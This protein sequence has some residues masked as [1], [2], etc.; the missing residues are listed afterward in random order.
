[1]SPKIL[2]SDDD[3][4][5]VK[6]LRT[7]LEAAGYTVFTASTVEGTLRAFVSIPSIDLAILDR[8]LPDGDGLDTLKGIRRID[9]SVPCVFIS[10]AAD[11][12]NT[13]DMLNGGADFVFRKPFEV[14]QLLE[15]VA[16]LVKSTVVV[17]PAR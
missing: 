11:A 6:L 3:E 8:F 12:C 4:S 17:E 1:M 13:A 7:V 16:D 10:G 5:V 9:P 14:Q 2:I 15:I